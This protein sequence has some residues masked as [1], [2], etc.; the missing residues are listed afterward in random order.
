MPILSN[1]M[2]NYLKE[3]KGVYRKLK[4]FRGNWGN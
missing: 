4:E 1:I 2:V 3:S